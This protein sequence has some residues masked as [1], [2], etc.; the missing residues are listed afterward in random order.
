ML[1][2]KS[3]VISLSLLTLITTQADA[4]SKQYYQYYVKARPANLAEGVPVVN[5]TGKWLGDHAY[6]VIKKKKKKHGKYKTI[7]NYHIKAAVGGT[8]GGSTRYKWRVRKNSKSKRLK[9]AAKKTQEIRECTQGP[10]NYYAINVV[11]HQ[12]ANRALYALPGHPTIG[13]KVRGYKDGLNSKRLYKKYGN[14]PRA[15]SRC[16]WKTYGKVR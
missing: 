14:S 10:G 13:R 15:W 5:H 6:I 8:S 4:G 11:C 3:L 1:S 7:R 2:K 16:Y 12:H 9:D